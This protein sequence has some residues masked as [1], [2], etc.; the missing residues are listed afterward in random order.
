MRGFNYLRQVPGPAPS[1]LDRWKPVLFGLAAGMALSWLAMASDRQALEVQAQRQQ[2]VQARIQPLEAEL[3]VGRQQLARL[4]AQQAQAARLESW[5]SH[6]R[7][8]LA[9]MEELSRSSGARITQLVFDEQALSVH[10]RIAPGQLQD[11]AAARKIGDLGAPE[12]VEVARPADADSTGASV[13]FVLR[14]PL[15]GQ[16]G[17]P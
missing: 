10:G 2:A 9:V 5:Q 13:Q 15:P 11:W 6:R 8:L 7:Q 3:A 4:Q 12:L 1:G 17:R 14:W 16:K